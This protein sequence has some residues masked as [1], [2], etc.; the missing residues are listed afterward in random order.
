MA[1]LIVFSQNLKLVSLENFK[2]KIASAEKNVFLTTH[3]LFENERFFISNLFPNCEFVD[4]ADFLTDEE[5]AECDEEAYLQGME[6]GT[7]LKKMKK[8]KNLMV[9][10]KAMQKFSPKGKFIFSDDL[11]ID[12]FVWS[13][14]G[15]RKLYGEYYY[16][17]SSK[18]GIRNKFAQNVVLKRVYRFLRGNKLQRKIEYKPEEVCVG[19]YEGRKYVFLGKMSRIGYRLNIPFMQSKEE[20]EKL[21]AGEYETKDNCTYMTTWH[22]HGKC[23]VPDDERYAVRWAQDGYL[24]PNY[25]HHDYDYKPAN[26][27][28][29]C[30]DVLGT[31]LFKNRNL[32]YE[33]IPFRKKLYIPEP[34]FPKIVKNVLVVASGS[35]D[36]TAL[37]NR[38]DDDIMV[39]AFAQ[40]AK[41]FPD[42]HFTYRCH[43]TWVHPLNVGVNAINRVHDY[44]K[45]LNLP[46]LT[47]SS[48]M[49]LS[50]ENGKFQFSFS[51][52]SLDEDLKNADIV[53]GE[54][55]ISMIDAA[56]KGK[57]F[58]SVNLTKRRNFFV[59]INDLGFPSVSS[60][61]GI[62]NVIET[63]TNDEFKE[64]YLKAVKGYNEM[65]DLDCLG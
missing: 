26:V 56:F 30:W 39:D 31:Q 12:G 59:G 63:V 22:E 13:K 61:D 65:T 34:K 2:D 25:T 16:R 24:P 60:H 58:C 45:W 20:C 5:M 33:M 41:R 43:P 37:K 29:Y 53:F 50:S 64:R 42:I 51:R 55:S 14:N 19:Y 7:Y 21:N 46:N 49:P 9:L 47:L 10:D 11:G 17:E 48:N 35:G 62:A 52:S 6:Y 8:I 44:F 40:M 57:P 4:F 38:S 23:N 54:H 32:P 15:F 28:Y 36:W 1:S 3:F 27:V 18:T